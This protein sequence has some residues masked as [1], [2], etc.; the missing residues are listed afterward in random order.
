MKTKAIQLI[1][2]EGFN[3]FKNFRHNFVMVPSTLLI[4][5]FMFGVISELN[6]E[7]IIS[8]FFCLGVTSFMMNLI[9]DFLKKEFK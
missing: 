6:K 5:G 2:D 7:I 3:I 4:L 1:K 8:C 9:F